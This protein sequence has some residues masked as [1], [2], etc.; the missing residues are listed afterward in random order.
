MRPSTNHQPPWQDNRWNGLDHMDHKDIK[1]IKETC[2]YSSRSKK[3]Y[4]MSIQGERGNP[5]RRVR[6]FCQY[7][8]SFPK[9]PFTMRESESKS[10]NFLWCSS[11]ILWN[12]LT[13]LWSFSLS[14]GV[15][16]PLHWHKPKGSFSLNVQAM[17][18]RNGFSSSSIVSLHN[19][20]A[21]TKIRFRFVIHSLWTSPKSYVKLLF[22]T[23]LDKS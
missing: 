16:R 1:S 21:N 9:S 3:F 11:L 12:F 22:R 8:S 20:A 18:L 15:N 13:V 4:P 17:S 5:E 2:Y 23:D 7:H 10:E 19:K 14:P 6:R